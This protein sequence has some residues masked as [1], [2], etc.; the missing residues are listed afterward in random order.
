[1]T[2]LPDSRVEGRSVHRMA[3]CWWR[4]CWFVHR[5]P[6]IVWGACSVPEIVIHVSVLIDRDGGRIAEV[7]ENESLGLGKYWNETCVIL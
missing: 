7:E 1:M 4:R 5:G 2:R 3:R 6:G